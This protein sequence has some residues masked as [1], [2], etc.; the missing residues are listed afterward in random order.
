MDELI[1]DH[2]S[3]DSESYNNYTKK[4]HS[5]KKEVANWRKLYASVLDEGCKK[6]LNVGCGPGTEAILLAGMGYEVTA[7]DFSPR[8]VELTK[9]NSA[10]MG[11]CVTAVVGDAEQLPFE[12][13]TFDAVVSN[14]ALWAIPHPQTAIDEWHRVL[15]SGGQIAYIDGIWSTA[16]YSKAR[17]LWT[18]L[19]SKLR[20]KDDNSHRP[21]SSPEEK[22]R[23][24]E[25]WSVTAQR[26]ADD[27][28]MV[29][30]AGFRNIL[31]IDK[32]DRRIFSGM[33]YVEYGYHKVHFMI[34]GYKERS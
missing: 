4:S 10:E 25:L 20:K 17:K 21:S 1:R 31:K 15:K 12:D 26:P 5:I 14:Y 24:S 33:R 23:M 18:R 29:E 6:I 11:V 27:L 19:A 32:V 3:R 16:G 34:I 30:T 13:G 28:R 22:E 9:E 2:F 8:M 7:L